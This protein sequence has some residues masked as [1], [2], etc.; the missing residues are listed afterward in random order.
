MASKNENVDVMKCN[1]FYLNLCN[2]CS[3]PSSTRHRNMYWIDDWND[4]FKDHIGRGE[5]RQILKRL[6]LYPPHDAASHMETALK[7]YPEAY[8]KYQMLMVLK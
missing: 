8:N 5:D 6:I 4:F 3:D 7:Q 1:F 2:F